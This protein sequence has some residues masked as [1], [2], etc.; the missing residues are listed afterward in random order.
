MTSFD[1]AGTPDAPNSVLTYTY[2]SVGN[3]LTVSDMIDG[4]AGAVTEYEYDGLNRVKTIKQSGSNVSEKLIDYVYNEI[5]QYDQVLRYSDLTRTNLVVGTDYEYDEIN[6]L[7][8]LRHTDNADEVLAFFTY[9]HDAAS[10]ITE[11]TDVNGL[12]EFA[13]D[14]RS[15]LIEADRADTDPRVDEFYQYDANG[16]RIASHLHGDGYE[17]GPANR[18]LSD[19]T[20]NYEYD[21]EGNM[22]RRTN[23]ESGEYRMFE[24]DHRNRLMKVEDFN[25]AETSINVAVMA[26]DAVDRR[27]RRMTDTDGSGP[28]AATTLHFVYDHS[29]VIADVGDADTSAR[30]L[31]G[32]TIDSL[33]FTESSDGSFAALTDHLGS[34]S[35]LHKSGQSIEQSEYD[36]FGVTDNGVA[37]VGYTGREFDDSIGLQFSRARYYEANNGRFLSNDPIGFAGDDVNLYRYVANSPLHFTDPTG[38]NFLFFSLV[39]LGLAGAAFY[40]SVETN[41]DS[42]SNAV[43]LGRDD[44]NGVT[45]QDLIDSAGNAVNSQRKQAIISQKTGEVTSQ[46]TQVEVIPAW[47]KDLLEDRSPRNPSCE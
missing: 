27:V 15:Q 46:P 13:Y 36:S 4:V 25:T 23:I 33:E 10:R 44:M 9:G 35:S 14:N 22:V 47:L 40:W 26:Y 28:T 3:V 37:R 41:Q 6:R 12:T 32:P 18:L 19:G 24:W 5:G 29:Q 45:G 1:N 43:Q 2:D 39:G 38:N 31:Y 20:Y 30:Y 21:D 16:N 34:V 7:A 11:I 42:M 17:T 8:D